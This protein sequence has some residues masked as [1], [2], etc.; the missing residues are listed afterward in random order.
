M[1][2]VLKYIGKCKMFYTMFEAMAF[3]DKFDGCA[4]GR[5]SEKAIC[6]TISQTKYGFEIN[7]LEKIIYKHEWLLSFVSDLIKELKV[8]VSLNER[9]MW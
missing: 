8:A 3:G 7:F 1:I 9:V 2:F 6:C 4:V 5:F